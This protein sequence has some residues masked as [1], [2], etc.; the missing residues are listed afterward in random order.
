M[1]I[2][3]NRKVLKPSNLTDNVIDTGTN[4]LQKYGFPCTLCIVYD[5]HGIVVN[6]QLPSFYLWRITLQVFLERSSRCPTVAENTNSS[7]D[8]NISECNDFEKL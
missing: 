1:L 2:K 8:L 7:K 3:G 4:K 5:L 6:V